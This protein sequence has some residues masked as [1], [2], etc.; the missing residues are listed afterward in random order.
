MTPVG[1]NYLVWVVAECLEYELDL[2]NGCPPQSG[3]VVERNL[4]VQPCANH[5]DLD[6]LSATI[7]TALGLIRRQKF[8]LEEFRIF[9]SLIS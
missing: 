3:A 4:R 8:V 2:S 1:R 6:R 7:N 9:F 5:K